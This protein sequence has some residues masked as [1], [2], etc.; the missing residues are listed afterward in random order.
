MESLVNK[1]AD[2]V[3]NKILLD[4]EVTQIDPE[5]HRVVT[6][7]GRIFPYTQLILT[8]PLPEIIKITKD[9][10]SD[11]AH[12]VEQLEFLSVLCVNVGVRRSNITPRHW[13]YFPEPEFL[14]HRIFVQGNAS[15]NVCPEG[16][17]SYTAEITYNANKT[18]NVSSA[19]QQTIQGLK[20]AG[21]LAEGDVIEVVDLI[22]IPYGY[23]VPT[24]GRLDVRDRVREWF[25]PHGIH[26]VGRFA[27]WEYYNMDHALNAGWSM[28]DHLN[29]K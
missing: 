1:L 10:P 20:L 21:L 14:F 4:A 25:A 8:A 23:V 3:K 19:G 22:D 17:F 26:L 27:E 16:C 29:S 28:A 24:R 12:Q 15:P 9:V 13:I 11:L 6:G 5:N 18:I 7:G 2:P